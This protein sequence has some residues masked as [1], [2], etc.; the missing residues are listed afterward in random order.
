MYSLINIYIYYLQ[1]M[2]TIT[3][4][5]AEKLSHP[6]QEL[7]MQNNYDVITVGTIDLVDVNLD[8]EDDKFPRID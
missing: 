2:F 3:K 6:D 8:D 4:E 7:E 5:E 1:Y